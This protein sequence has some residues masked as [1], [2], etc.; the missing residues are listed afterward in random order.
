MTEDS[1]DVR[2]VTL[3]GDITIDYGTATSGDLYTK[4]TLWVQDGTGGRDRT[5]NYNSGTSSIVVLGTAI[6][7]TTLAAGDR[8]WEVAVV[9]DGTLYIR[10][11]LLAAS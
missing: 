5:N 3:G 8:V 9:L 6:D 4:A 10:S 7:F 1:V 2:K 11:E